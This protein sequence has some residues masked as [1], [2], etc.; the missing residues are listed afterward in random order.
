MCGETHTDS[1]EAKVSKG[2]QGESCSEA[3]RASLK[4]G[5]IVSFSE[6]FKRV[7]RRGSWKD[8]T[9]WQHLMLLVVN[10]PPARRHWK[11]SVPFLFLHSDGRYEL[12][13]PK[14]HPQVQ[15]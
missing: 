14:I 1:R 4:P 9:I 11:T 15:E 6:L 2:H 5:E 12:Y 3:I 10:L 8:E 13:D 7:R